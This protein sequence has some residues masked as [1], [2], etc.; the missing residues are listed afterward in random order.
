[1]KV[2]SAERYAYACARLHS[3]ENRMPDS[4]AF[5]RL[6]E[7]ATVDD[8]IKALADHGYDISEN[9]LLLDEELKKTLLLIKKIAPAREYLMIF[10]LKNDYHNLKVLIK[11]ERL[12][13]DN[14]A[15]LEE[16]G[17]YA[18]GEL[19]QIIRDREYS[20]LP[21]YMR[22]ALIRISD[23]FAKTSD[24]QLIDIILDEAYFSHCF[25]IANKTGG[26]FLTQ[27]LKLTADTRNIVTFFRVK[28]SRLGV[29]FLEKVLINHGNVPIKAYALAYDKSVDE[30]TREFGGDRYESIIKL[31]YESMSNSDTLTRLEKAADEL[32]ITFIKRYRYAPFGIEPVIAHI[33]AKEYEIK[34][35]RIILSG[36]T[37]GL[38]PDMIKE[39]VRM[40]YA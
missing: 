32:L 21:K 3:I 34:N 14:T 18:T 7:S 12:L 5:M 27:Y 33:T 2:G 28:R 29:P 10:Y 24:P 19:S 25:Y 26:I 38:M 4:D 23:E 30:A 15:L 13:S 35:I 39:R 16:N 20:K 8:V 17:S 36:I 31:G 9:M 37:N 11:S 1:M 22:D 40:S 6:C